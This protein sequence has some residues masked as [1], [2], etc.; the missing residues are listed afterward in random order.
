MWRSARRPLLGWDA[1]RSGA[2]PFPDDAEP[3]YR[4][5][6][7]V[8]IHLGSKGGLDEAA[9]VTLSTAQAFTG[10]GTTLAAGDVDGDGRADLLIGCPRASGYTGRVMA[11]ASSRTRTAGETIDVDAPGATA[12]DLTGDT[13]SFPGWF[14]ASIAQIGRVLLVGAPYERTNST[15]T[16]NCAITGRVYGLICHVLALGRTAPRAMHSS[17]R[18]APPLAALVTPC[19]LH[20][21]V[22]IVAIAAPDA[23]GSR[24]EPR[25]GMVLLLKGSTV[26]QLRGVMT[27]DEVSV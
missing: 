9:K 23:P 3:T 12:L 27:I 20:V 8:Y 16:R 26:A 11:V 17:P 15:C 6:G 4:Q 25:A 7:R 21:G 13:S 2:S 14:G 24:G 1:S 10:L 5:F 19:C 22:P 18:E